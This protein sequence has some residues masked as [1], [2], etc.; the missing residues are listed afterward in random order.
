MTRVTQSENHQPEKSDWPA[1]GFGELAAR[2]LQRKLDKKAVGL[3]AC[4]QN[5]ELM[6]DLW[7]EG[8]PEPAERKQAMLAMY[9]KEPFGERSG[10]KPT[11]ENGEKR[12]IKF[13]TREQKRPS[14]PGN[15]S[16]KTPIKAAA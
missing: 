10:T 4:C 15:V 3:S 6:S 16:V 9:C 5:E 8:F 1:L 12:L 13:Q 11:R 2:I 7:F 14:R